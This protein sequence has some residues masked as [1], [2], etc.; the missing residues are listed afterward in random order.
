MKPFL[1]NLSGNPTLWESR[2]AEARARLPQ[3]DDRERLGL[4]AELGTLARYLGDA[5][6]SISYCETGLALTRAL[7]DRTR[8]AASLVRLGGA[9]HHSD[10][11]TALPRAESCF[12]QVIECDDPAFLAYRDFAWQHLGKLLAEQDDFVAARHCFE[13]ALTLRLIKQ[14]SE[15]MASTRQALDT[16]DAL[17]TSAEYNEDKL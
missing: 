4:L 13:Q 6:A 14:D 9:L 10:D 5:P 15:L 11:P 1:R 12:R 8:E 17:E 16:L 7:A 3:A 2:Y